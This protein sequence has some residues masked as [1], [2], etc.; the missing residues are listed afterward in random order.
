LKGAVWIPEPDAFSGR[1]GNPNCD[2]MP[3]TKSAIK[4]ARQNLKRRAIN[5]AALDK[6]KSAVKKVKKAATAGKLDDANKA[7][8]EAF[9]AYDKA[10][11]KN[12]IHQNN[13]ARHKSR[14]SKLVGKMA[15]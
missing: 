14:L 2:V 12:I 1:E 5:L 7:L 15:K 10:A 4:A 13:A 8:K 3:N 11:K 9:A 6:I